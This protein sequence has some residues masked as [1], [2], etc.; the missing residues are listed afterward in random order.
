MPPGLVW[1]LCRYLSDPTHLYTFAENGLRF[2]VE[3]NFL[4]DKSNGFQLESSPNRNAKSLSGL[5]L[6]L[7]A[8]TRYL[9]IVCTVVVEFELR[10]IIATHWQ[11]SL[12]YFKIG[13]C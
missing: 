5:G 10:K 8:A 7:A 2:D 4:D 6:V 12:S 9:T 1:G 13:W 11:R 3:E